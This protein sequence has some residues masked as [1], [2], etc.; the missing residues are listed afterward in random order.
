MGRRVERKKSNFKRKRSRQKVRKI[1]NDKSYVLNLSS[2]KLSINEKAVLE[3]GLKF[4]PILKG[5]KKEDILKDF[6]KFSRKLRLKWNFRNN[7]NQITLRHPFKAKSQ[8]TPQVTDNNNLENYIK[9]TKLEIEKMKTPK[10][11][12]N[13][14]KGELLGLKNLA[15]DKDIVIRKADKNS[16]IVIQN[17]EDYK[18]EGLRQ[19][20]DGVHYLRLEK[21]HSCQINREASTLIKEMQYNKKS[22]D[23]YTYLY[24]NNSQTEF[25]DNNFFLL[26][27]I[28]KVPDIFNKYRK[29]NVIG[30]KLSIPGRPITSQTGSPTRKIAKFLSEILKPIV[31]KQETFVK[32]SKDALEK[33]EKIEL[34]ENDW[35]ITY[36]ISNMF[37]S[38][39]IDEM[40]RIV[41]FDLQ[42]NE[43]I[44]YPF[45]RPKT[46]EVIQLVNLYLKNA[47]IMFD[48]KYWKQTTGSTMGG[49]C[50]GEICDI[51]VYH[52]L[53]YI[54]SKAN[55]ENKIRAHYRFKDD[56][57]II[58]KS[59]KSEAVKFFE[60]ANE[61]HPNI[62][63]KN[64]ISFTEGIF[65]D[66]HIFKG[67]N[68]F[69]ESK[70]TSKVYRKET[71]IFQFLHPKSGHPKHVFIGFIR[72]E[73]IRFLR[74]TNK[75]I[76]FNE[77]INDF[78]NKL[79]DRGYKENLIKICNQYKF[80][81]RPRYMGNTKKCGESKLVFST[82]FRHNTKELKKVLFEHWRF[83]EKDTELN[84]LFTKPIIAYKKSNN[85]KDIIEKEQRNK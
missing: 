38:I 20:D 76:W 33:L 52:L 23:D 66:L 24:L 43:H 26:P 64:E 79:R 46:K 56:G 8:Y 1:E 42:R 27:K 61:I 25:W 10:I 57:I 40:T 28:H 29:G 37:T 19:L 67:R 18:N 13:L 85:I 75:K 22:F 54:I 65:L 17:V 44:E 80:E 5:Q 32:N 48:N 31:E 71:E 70:L 16:M 72:G 2:R 34:G 73:C 6:V 21:S 77:K 30:D 15:R 51:H 59:T 14:T 3:K 81:D 55:C 11:T 9:M 83:I 63:F 68:E 47:E 82:E 53:N 4:V 74:N 45:K 7:Q 58:W 39:P 35:I 60:I 41:E 36:D 50:S 69:K 78:K 62:K 49:S 84:K 12:R